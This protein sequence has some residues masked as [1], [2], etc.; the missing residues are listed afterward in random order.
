MSAPSC[1]SIWPGNS[2][3]SEAKF[4]TLEGG[5]GVGKSTQAARLVAHLKAVGQDAI[6]TRE[7]GGSPKAEAIREVLLSGAAA[8]FGPA[9]EAVLFSA[10][11]VD[12]LAALIRPALARG[13][14]VV[15][16]RFSDSTRAYQGA[17]GHVDATLLAGLERI[18]VGSTR[19]HLTLI[20]DLPQ[21]LGLARARMRPGGAADRFE[22]QDDAFHD[23]LRHAFLTIAAAE[24]KRCAVIDAS[25]D[26]ELVAQAIWQAVE[27]R[28][29]TP[30]RATAAA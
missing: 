25:L 2:L 14:W 20:L 22:S 29:L 11:R 9:A 21:R 28:L 19:P 3:V 6:A 23:R 15:C 12:H 27:A 17:A 10:A 26:I 24:P 4:I 5:E 13:S 1:G 8:P 18:A 30:S 16:D 7:P